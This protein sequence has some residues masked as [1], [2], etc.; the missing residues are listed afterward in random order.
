[1]KTVA[2][3]SPRILLSIQQ[4]RVL[5]EDFTA[6][7]LQF[8]L[9]NLNSGEL[10]QGTVN[11]LFKE[12]GL[13]PATVRNTTSP[14]ALKAYY[15][16]SLAAGVPLLLISSTYHSAPR[17]RDAGIPIDVVFNDEAHYLVG[18]QFQDCFNLGTYQYSFTATQKITDSPTGRGMNNREL[19]GD[20]VYTKSPKAL[21]GAGEI[22]APAI[23][24]VD[25]VDGQ[26]NI[27][28]DDY[29]S[30]A[31]CIISAYLEHEKL[32]KTRASNPDRIGAKLLVTCDGQLTLKAILE[33]DAFSDFQ[34]DNLDV[35]LFALSSD[36]GILM[37]GLT[38]KGSPKAKEQFIDHLGRMSHDDRALII[39]VDMLAEGL[40]VPGITGIM[41]FR[42]LGPSKFLQTLGRATRLHNDDRSRLYDG[43]L[44]SADHASFIKP[45]AWVVIPRIMT[46][47]R[48]AVARYL[49][50][51]ESVR[52]EFEFMAKDL[53][54]VDDSNGISPIPM[55]ELVNELPEETMQL[56]RASIEAFFHNIEDGEHTALKMGE[57]WQDE[58]WLSLGNDGLVGCA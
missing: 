25:A 35:K 2:I 6:H 49:G 17:L 46:N 34:L 20:V 13:D 39:H 48:D 42:N 47:G 21:I 1:M 37:N 57:L 40:D 5:I 32:I 54:I 3:L 27:A 36:Y 31:R 12:N 8:N 19:F 24:I 38:V 14:Q 28:D 10:D 30:L 18:E 29:E 22:V 50:Y 9:I 52:T 53:V 58:L 45:F 51:V 43:T 41:P 15:D 23:H 16:E 7:K 11:R 33:T 56:S 55:P 4:L 26:D 44:Q